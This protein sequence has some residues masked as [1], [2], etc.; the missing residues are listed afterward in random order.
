MSNKFLLDQIR[1]CDER[2]IGEQ[3][4]LLRAEYLSTYVF[5]RVCRVGDIALPLFFPSKSRLI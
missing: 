1:A 3:R 2:G 4:L 5:F